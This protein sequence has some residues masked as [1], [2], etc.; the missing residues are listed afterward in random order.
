MTH[1][2]ETDNDS[3]ELQMTVYRNVSF[4]PKEILDDMNSFEETDVQIQ[5]KAHR[6]GIKK[7]QQKAKVSEQQVYANNDNNMKALNSS[8][9]D[10]RTMEEI[11]AVIWDKR[12]R[13]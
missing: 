11:Q 5:K 6:E 4:V 13:A 8:N 10:R 12:K 1:R 2:E 9:R 7:K 3:E